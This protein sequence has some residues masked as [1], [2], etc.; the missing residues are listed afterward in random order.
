MKSGY[1]ILF[2]TLF[3]GNISFA[4][5]T[6]KYPVEDIP[7]ELLIAADAV[8]REKSTVLEVISENRIECREKYVITILKESGKEKAFFEEYYDKLSSIS[9][10]SATVYNKDGKKIKVIR[11]DDIIDLTA[12]SGF[13]LYDDSRKKI[14]DPKYAIYPYT[15]EY[16][17]DKRYNSA[18]YLHG[19]SAFLGYNTSVEKLSFKIISPASYNFYYKE[20]NLNEKAAEQQVDQKKVLS[21]EFKGFKALQYEPL[22]DYLHK[23]VPLVNIAPDKFNLDGYAGSLKSWKEFGKFF[24]SLNS[25]KDNIPQETIDYVGTLLNEEMTDYDKIATIYKFSQDKNRYVSIQEG[26]GGQQPFD[27]KT[28]DRLSYGDCKALSN[29]VVTLLKKFGFE[30]YYTLVYSGDYIYTD[31]EFVKDYFNHVIACV[32]INNNDTIWLECTNSYYPCGYLGS[33]TDNRNVLLIKEDGGELAKT[34]SYSLIDNKQNSNG[35]ATISQ[36]GLVDIDINITYCGTMYS[37]QYGLLLLDEI[38]KKKKIIQSID[39]PDFNL[40][41]YKITTN[42]DR[43]PS[44]NKELSISVTHFASKMG[45]RMFFDLNMM[46]Q[47]SFTLPYS[48]NRISPVLIFRPFSEVDSIVYSLPQGYKMEALPKP[49]ELKS[50]FGEYSSQAKSEDNKIYYERSVKIWNGQYPKEKYNEF[51]EFLEKI[52]KHDEAKAVLIKEI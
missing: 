30:A 21:W 52:A 50:E 36:D 2:I 22:S 18:Y 49:I 33:S 24:A 25:G 45:D 34:P 17:F 7:T 44:L 32:P 15:V 3:Y 46:N 48:R 23:W 6:P 35:E 9:N 47:S 28:V 13:S 31:K 41:N 51:V 37:D 26:I 39:I 19:W 43:K 4:K 11:S 16:T 5:K 29:Y 10:I 8:V 38:D 20:F 14:I 12:V 1:F 40:L 27:A 42:N